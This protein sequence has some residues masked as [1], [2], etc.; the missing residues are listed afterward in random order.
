MATATTAANTGDW[1]TALLKAPIFQRLPPINLQKILLKLEPIDFAKGEVIISQGSLGDYYYL[2]KSGQCLCTRQASPHAKAINIRQLE[3]G[4]TFGEDALLSGRPRD[5]TIT[6]LTDMSLLRLDKERFVS[7]I[8]EPSLTFVSYSEMQQAIR[9]GAI[10]LD[11]RMQEDYAKQ[12]LKGSINAPFFSLRMQVKTLSREKS[13][14][15]VCA[16]G[17]ISEAAAFLLLNNKI[18]ASILKGGIAGVSEAPGEE[19]TLMSDAE[20]G[21]IQ[22][23]SQPEPG[24]LSKDDKSVQS[25]F[26]QYFEPLLDDCCLRLDLEFGVQLSRKREA[27]GSDQYHKLREYLR[28]VRDQILQNYVSNIHDHF[29]NPGY[30]PTL[31]NPDE[32]AY[33]SNLALSSDDEITESHALALIIRQCEK[34]FYAELT[35]LNKRLAHQANKQSIT[36]STHPIF[37]KNLVYALVDTLKPLKLNT[38]YRI[39][40]YKIFEANVFSQLGVVYRELLNPSE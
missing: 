19:N 39:V 21:A 28:S 27:I 1:M 23:N 24:Q 22:E 38:E 37:P 40:L 10:V 2:V 25:I 35:E 5:L 33:S 15:I 31:N 17:K 16:E 32:A 36:D 4:D 11:V 8:K 29:A 7:L 9:Q 34:L 30:R 12:H 26:F 20:T 18:E 13:Y 3:A 6:A 14:V